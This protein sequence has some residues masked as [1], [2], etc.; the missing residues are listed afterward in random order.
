MV[1][2]ETLPPCARTRARSAASEASVAEREVRAQRLQS[3]RVGYYDGV[4]YIFVA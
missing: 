2:P 1:T 4:L 3:E